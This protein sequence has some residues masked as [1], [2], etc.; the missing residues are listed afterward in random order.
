M[1]P[2]SDKIFLNYLQCKYKAYLKF[3]DKTGIMSD[4]EKF[5]KEQ[6]TSYRRSAREYFRQSIQ[7]ITLPKATTTFKDIKN[8]RLV[9]ITDVSI[10]NERHDLTLDA[11]ELESSLS[12]EKPA[13]R[14]IIYLPHQKTTKQDKL[15]LAFCG[16]ALSYEQKAEPKNGRF[17]LG[18][19][20]SSSRVLLSPLIKTAGK[21]EKEIVKMMETQTPPLLRLNDHCQICEFQESC[22]TTVKEKNDLSLLRG[23][24]GKEI[25]TLNKRGIFTVTQYS[26]TFRPRRARKLLSKN[27][28]KHHYSLNALAIR[29]QTIYIAGKP[30]LSTAKTRIFLDVEG[31]PDENIYYLIGLIVDDGTNVTTHSLWA[32]SKSEEIT[33]WKLFLAIMT[34]FDDYVLF[35]YG[36]YETKFIKQMGTQYGG[37]NELLERIKSRSFNV[38]S[39]IYGRI[40]FPTYSNDLKSIASFLGFKWSDQNASGLASVLWRIKWD[41]SQDEALKRRI[42]TYNYEDC[43]ALRILERSLSSMAEDSVVFGECTIK[44][45]DELKAEKPLGIFK[46]NEFIFPELDKINKKAYWDYQRSK[47]Y[48]RTNS[49]VKKAVVKKKRAVRPAYRINR[50]VIADRLKRCP[51][52]N[53]RKP[54]KHNYHTRVVYDLKMFEGGIKRFVTRYYFTRFMCKKCKKTFYPPMERDFTSTQYGRNL[55][56]WVIYQ[57]IAR[58]K[59]QGTIIDD[60]AEIFNYRLSPAIVAHFKERTA[61]TYK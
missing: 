61:K 7:T 57:S 26:Y 46:R 6:N 30:E 41:K 36:S 18:E 49:A 19:K 60:L 25:D 23:L 27:I 37:D 52:C 4:Y 40:Y 16:L 42:I 15:L 56:G 28:I 3:Y 44:N 50:E 13:Y 51:K 55:V 24:S 31:I 29:T 53:A 58:L 39:A 1:H 59:S 47:I 33:I 32:N 9:A 43:L 20:F 45:A 10:V 35:H 8:R 21:I 5:S 48:L 11:I 22:H 54:M 34:K 17:I 38:L 12:L 14:P 2:I